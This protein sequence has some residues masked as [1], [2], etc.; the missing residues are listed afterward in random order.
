MLTKQKAIETAKIFIDKGAVFITKPENLYQKLKN[1][2]AFIFDWDGVF[3]S[4]RKGSHR[5][6][7]FA[8]PDTMGI[9]TLRYAYWLIHGKLPYLAII[10]GQNNESAFEFAKRE[11][12][13][14]VFAGYKNKS[15]AINEC[16]QH[17]QLQA[18]QIASVFDDIIDYPLMTET[19]VRFLCN[20]TSSPLFLQTVIAHQLCDYITFSKHPD[21]PIREISE[22]VIGF[23]GNYEQMFFS[24]FTEKEKYAQFWQLRQ[25]TETQIIL[26]NDSGL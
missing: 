15:I 11:H 16:K 8:E 20:R 1:I 13:H 21:Y 9:H 25:S 6:S 26:N 4:G 7:D 3:N 14:A 10:T 2:D 18:H 24:R 23:W 12:L 17:F 5:T 22:V 19:H